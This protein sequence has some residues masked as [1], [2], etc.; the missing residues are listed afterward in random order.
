M[1]FIFFLL[2]LSLSPFFTLFAYIYFWPTRSFFV[3]F[4]CFLFLKVEFFFPFSLLVTLAFFPLR[5]FRG[6]R[7]ERE[8]Q[9][10]KHTHTPASGRWQ[11]G[12]ERAGVGGWDEMGVGEHIYTTHIVYIPVKCHKSWQAASRKH[13]TLKNTHLSFLCSYFQEH[14][15]THTDAHQRGRICCCFCFLIANL[16]CCLNFNTNSSTNTHL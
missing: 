4:I 12:K 11:R 16:Q 6:C 1:V 2:L 3:V 10:D 7:S 9:T 15:H 5:V 8:I 13:K 14:N